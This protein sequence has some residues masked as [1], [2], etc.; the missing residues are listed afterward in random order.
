[1]VALFLCAK[2]LTAVDSVKHWE[3]DR[4]T[5]FS[6]LPQLVIIFFLVNDRSEGQM[7]AFR[8]DLCSFPVCRII[9]RNIMWTGVKVAQ[10]C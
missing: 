9:L 1:M 10:Y 7:L 2:P 3:G 4:E 5:S 8:Q 6:T